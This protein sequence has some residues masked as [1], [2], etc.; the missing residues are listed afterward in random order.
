MK[1]SNFWRTVFEIENKK[2]EIEKIKKEIESPDFWLKE[3]NFSLIEKL[4]QLENEINDF[5]ELKKIENLIEFKKKLKSIFY[6]YILK[7][8]YDK[9]KTIVSIYSGTGGKDA[10]D[11]VRILSRMYEKFFERMN[12]EYLWLDEEKNEYDG[13]KYISFQIE[14]DFSYGILKW[15]RGVHRLVRISP[16][17]A[18]RLR[19]TSFAYVDVIPFIEKPE[20]K[21]NEKDIEIQ[22]FRSSGRGGQNVNKVETAVRVIY[23]PLNIVVV[24]QNERYQ[25][26]NKELALQILY[27]RIQKILEEKQKKE[28]E[29][30]KGEKIEISWGNQIRSYVFDPY[31]LV[32]DLKSKR[33]TNKLEEVLDGNLSLIHYYGPIL[34]FLMLK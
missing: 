7:E 1:F 26:R 22:T 14:E 9:N 8:K 5:E 15:E 11:W 16:F 2:K 24:C 12:W 21:I 29:E 31:K 27:S 13:Y 20:F 25:H 4:N 23:K 32:K 19:H 30:I 6:K 10:E 33:E 34:S 17:S 18:Q 3:E 28:I